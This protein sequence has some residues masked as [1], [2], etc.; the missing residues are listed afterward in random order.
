ML[1]KLRVICDDL[2][3]K[4]YKQYIR[5]NIENINSDINIFE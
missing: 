4:E 3:E 5:Y 2:F 1:E